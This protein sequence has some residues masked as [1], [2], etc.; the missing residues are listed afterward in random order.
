MTAMGRSWRSTGIAHTSTGIAGL[1]D[2]VG[3]EGDGHLVI[4]LVLDQFADDVLFEGG[5]SGDGADQG[6]AG[7]H[8]ALLAQRLPQHEV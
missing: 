4:G 2:G 6:G 7:E 1:G 5:G 8:V 3:H